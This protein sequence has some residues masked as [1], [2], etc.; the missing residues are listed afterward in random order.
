MSAFL[1]ISYTF[2]GQI[3]LPVSHAQEIHVPTETAIL[4]IMTEFYI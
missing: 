3:T 4:T 1:N 2:V